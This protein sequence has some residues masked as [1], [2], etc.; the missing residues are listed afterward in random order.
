MGQCVGC[1]GGQVCAV[2][3]SKETGLCSGCV[4]GDG[5]LQWV[6]VRR[7]VCAM[8]VC[9]WKEIGLCTGSV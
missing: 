3:V 4:E 2:G 9:V 6:C 5:S 8:G 7:H 1:V